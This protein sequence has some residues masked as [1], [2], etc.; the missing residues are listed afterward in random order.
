MT[1]LT[2]QQKRVL[3]GIKFFQAEYQGEVPYNIL[4]LDLDILEEDLT[5]ILDYLEGENYISRRDGI[6]L[7]KTDTQR[8]KGEDTSQETQSEETSKETIGDNISESQL[9]DN[10]DKNDA[11]TENTDNKVDSGDSDDSEEEI[12]DHLSDVEQQSLDII[13]KLVNDSGN[14]SRTLLEG[15]LLYGELKLNSIPMYNLITSLENK[16]ILKK[17]KLTD[18]EYYHF[19][20]ELW[21]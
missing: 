5:E 6:I 17:I 21:S 2:P 16:G 19:T 12:K 14:I 4:K 15:T 11:A 13:T 8:Q 1:I 9:K 7:L 3:N 20:P 18:G 10:T